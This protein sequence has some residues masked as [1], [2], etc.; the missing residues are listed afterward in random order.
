MNLKSTAEENTLTPEA[1]AMLSKISENVDKIIK[2]LAGESLPVAIAA[3]VETAM[4]MTAHPTTPASVRASI[5]ELFMTQAHAMSAIVSQEQSDMP[6]PA[7][8]EGAP[9]I[10]LVN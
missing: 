6:Q 7:A 2:T 3:C 5:A 4:V 8:A 10:Q 9:L 1:N